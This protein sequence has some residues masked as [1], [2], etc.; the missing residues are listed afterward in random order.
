MTI[1]S[2]EYD[3]DLEKTEDTDRRVYLL[4]DESTESTSIMFNL[5]HAGYYVKHFQKNTDIVE[6]CE[7]MVPNVIMI[8]VG[9]NSPDAI[10]IKSLK[11]KL[12]NEVSFFIISDNDGLDIRLESARLGIDRFFG[13]PVN[14]NELVNTLNRIVSPISDSPYRILLVDNDKHFL[15]F[16][17]NILEL[18][19]FEVEAF[20]DPMLGLS[21]FNEFRPDVVLLDLHMPE[22]SGVEFLQVVRQDD[23]W[24]NIPIV[25][26]SAEGDVDRQVYSL[27]QGAIEFLEKPVS[28]DKLTTIVTIMAQRSRRHSSIYQQLSAALNDNKYHLI[29]N[30]EHNIV[31]VANVSGQITYVN[32][33]FCDVSEYS[34]AELLG[35]NHRLLKSDVHSDEFYQELWETISAGKI[36]HGTICNHTKSGKKYWVDSTIVPFLDKDGKPYKY[37]SA[38]TEVTELRNNEVIL[39][40]A[41]KLASLGNW[42][43]EN[44]ELIWSDE[45]YR[46]FGQSSESFKPTKEAYYSAIPDE[47][48]RKIK[49]A[50]DNAK[51]VGI[52]NVIH[53]V[54]RPNGD[55]RYVQVIAKS[56]HVKEGRD[57]LSSGTMQDITHRVQLEN[58]LQKRTVTLDMLHSTITKF[59]ETNDMHSSMNSMLDSLLEITGSEYGFIGEVIIDGDV[60]HIK[61]YA[62]SNTDKDKKAQELDEKSSGDAFGLRNINNLFGEVLA[63]GKFVI[64][65]DPDNDPNIGALPKGYPLLNSFMGVPVYYRDE[66]VGVYGVANRKNNYDDSMVELLK[67]FNTTYGVMIHSRRMMDKEV[68]SRNEIIK[69]KVDAEQANLAK[70]QFLSSMSHELRTP[71]NAIIGFSQLLAMDTD[72]PMSEI[73]HENVNEITVAG[74]HL[75]NLIDEV[76]DLSKIESGRIDVDIEDVSVGEVLLEALQLINALAITRGIEVILTANGDVVTYDNV[77]EHFSIVR[78]DAVRLKQALVNLLSNAVKYNNKNG[79]IKICC[80]DIENNQVRISVIDTGNGLT[81]EQ[82]SQLFIPFN[83]LG[84]GDSRKEGVGIGLVITKRIIEVMEGSVGVE[85]TPEEGCNFSIELKNSDSKRN[86]HVNSLDEIIKEKKK[87]ELNMDAQRKTVLY[88]EDN[89]ANLR[90]VTQMM[91]RLAN[92]NL[93][94]AHEP[95]L[96]IELA[97]EYLPDLILLDINLPGID[98]YEVLKRLQADEVTKNIPVIAISAN[99]MKK[100]IKKGLNAGCKDYITKPIDVVKLM[101]T[102]SELLKDV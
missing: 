89:P 40:Q 48:I 45:I 53:R 82:Q 67:P 13:K 75:L 97:K 15:K 24:V 69:A 30:N 57:A 58:E 42:R 88:I 51:I 77:V 5:E 95:Y 98:G 34:E 27:K 18:K 32:R 49:E 66:M 102:V 16:C 76:L 60:P 14:V 44:D 52:F 73:Q 79:K 19:G 71:M 9:C 83:R 47:D 86:D 70:S 11:L 61:T 63:S 59:V 80:D 38:R 84:A 50:E 21:E 92:V 100:D 22:C 23:E 74:K 41:Q 1:S 54:I 3:N 43:I 85:C 93:R 10:L 28:N 2:L 8:D 6:A 56:K 7:R 25:F 26:L 96:G 68:K 4:A 64:S 46:I 12:G 39:K 81:K 65:H 36:W 78:A 20:S 90:L 35:Q 99:A 17:R 91:G 31:S 87:D 101:K 37:V 55:I 94:S 72:P 29:A 62:S 33:K